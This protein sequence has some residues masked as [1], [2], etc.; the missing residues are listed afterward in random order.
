MQNKR[1][2]N[3]EY[4]ESFDREGKSYYEIIGWYDNPFYNAEE[5]LKKDGF[6]FDKNGW[7]HRSASGA[8]EHVCPDLLTRPESS[9]SIGTVK[10]NNGEWNLETYGDRPWTLNRADTKSF[11][12]IIEYLNELGNSK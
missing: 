7:A 12:R 1:I 2:G 10:W 5:Q 4:R 6:V 8:T 3:I 11:Q 9:Y